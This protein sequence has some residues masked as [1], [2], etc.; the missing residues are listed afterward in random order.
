[1]PCLYC[2]NSRL[3]PETEAETGRYFTGNFQVH[4]S[5]P[6]SIL[7]NVTQYT[8]ITNLLFSATNYT[9]KTRNCTPSDSIASIRYK[10]LTNHWNEHF[11]GHISSPPL[12][13]TELFPDSLVSL[14]DTI[15][16]LPYFMIAERSIFNGINWQ[17][18]NRHATGFDLIELQ[19][20][21]LI[22]CGT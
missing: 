3:Q 7:C 8:T 1:M 5:K 22:H 10:K 12:I 21:T 2:F 11:L 19:Y 13:A 6:D 4:S 16:P 9:P 20:H 15:H 18:R 17:D 14:I